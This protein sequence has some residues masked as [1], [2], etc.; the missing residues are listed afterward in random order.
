MIILTLTVKQVARLGL[1]ATMAWLPLQ[2]ALLARDLPTGA[3][4][5]ALFSAKQNDAVNYQD[6]VLGAGDKV[7][8]KFFNVPEYNGEVQVLVD[9]TLNLPLVG[10]VKVEDL[11][12]EKARDRLTTAYAPY[13]KNP[14]IDLNITAPRPLSVGVSGEVRRPGSYAITPNTSAYAVTPGSTGSTGWPSLINALQLAGG[15]TERANIKAIQIQR[16][17][18]DNRVT[19]LSLDLSQ[20]IQSGDTSQNVSLR[21]R[22]AIYIPAA[23]NLT[24]TELTQLS[25]VNFSPN[26]IRINVVGEV[27]KPGMVEVPPNTPLAQAIMAAGGF[28]QSRANTTTVD[29]IRLNADG[30]VSPRV[31]SLDIDQGINEATNPVLRNNDLVVVGRSGTATFTDS[32]GGIFGALSTIL[33]PLYLI[34]NLIR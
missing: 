11:S 1:V 32:F 3:S 13:L 14:G 33:N 23:N 4:S 12:L 21:D 10:K 19:T 17:G 26:T 16:R 25:A 9:G 8:V 2:P 27:Q 7:S 34:N 6:Y 18:P 20:L 22:D 30:S 28:N 5:H 31:V 29:L 15:I 24:P